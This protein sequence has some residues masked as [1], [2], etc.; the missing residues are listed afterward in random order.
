MTEREEPTDRIFEARNRRMIR[1]IARDR[2]LARASID[3]INASAP[4]EYAYHFKW[5]GM[6]IIQLPADIIALQEVI[7]RTKPDLIVET[8][9]ARGGSM[10]LYAS[11][12]ELI[13]GNGRVV[14][15]DIDIRAP[16]RRAIEAHKLAKRISLIEGS[17]I[18][19]R[20]VEK[21]RAL[22][23]RRKRVLV[24][25]DSNHTH[26][27]VARELELYAPLVRKG[28]YLIV[29]D[30]VIEHM[31]A[32]YFADRPWDRGN[33]PMTAVREFLRRNSRFVQDPEMEKLLI[34]AAPG[35]FLLCV[36]DDGEAKAG[37]R[38]GAAAGRRR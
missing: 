22:A 18:D 10:I 13:G 14:G 15:V 9:V 7:W 12:L 5:L 38:K 34:T 16:N 3:W 6:P 20:T 29:F 1:R 21:V 32:G 8:G 27:H 19:E 23:R 36:G 28:G 17:S 35:G 24:V 33:N 4:F 30:T 26:E 25:L 2:R 31:P 11:L 37:P